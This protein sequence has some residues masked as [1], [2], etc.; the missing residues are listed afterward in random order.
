MTWEVSSV[1]SKGTCMPVH[2]FLANIGPALHT[3]EIFILELVLSDMPQQRRRHLLSGLLPSQ[4][5]HA[6][7]CITFQP[8]E[9]RISP[10]DLHPGA[11][12][13]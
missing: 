11:R 3:W 4:E 5:A 8:M 12:P 13:R 9:D 1:L 6:I 2:D 10:E 7:Q